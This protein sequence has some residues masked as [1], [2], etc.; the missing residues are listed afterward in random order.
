MALDESLARHQV[1]DGAIP[2]LRFYGWSPA[3][4]SIGRFQRVAELT[5]R[6]CARSG[7]AGLDWVRRPT[8]GR[9]VWHGCEVT[10]SVCVSLE[11]VPE[12][13]RSVVGSYGWLSQPLLR[14]LEALGVRASLSSARGERFGARQRN[15]FASASQADAAVDG[16]KLIG[17]A[18]CRFDV[19]GRTAILQHGSILID[20]DPE[21]WGLALGEEAGG[22][23]PGDSSDWRSGVVTLRQVGLDG[24]AEALRGR[25]RSSVIKA[26]RATEG[27]REEPATEFEMAMAR[28][29]ERSKY[30]AE[31]WNGLGHS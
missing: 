18:Q 2:T 9:A 14:G 31:G 17:A 21:A 4:L 16:R 26:L 20:A 22:E 5:T 15:C 29:L 11:V 7:L 23:E 30:L 12:E 27:V 6:S 24:D 8:G 1:L 13:L 19:A 28:E 10:Y 25:V 3:C